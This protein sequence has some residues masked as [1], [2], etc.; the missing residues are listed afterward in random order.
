[1]DRLSL[2]WERRFLALAQHIAQWSKDPSTQVGAVIVDAD[3]RVVGMGYNG[4]PRGVYD[5]QFRYEDRE[6]KYPRVIHAEMNAILNA[7]HSVKDCALFSWPLNTCARCA[8]MIIQAGICTVYAQ[9]T[10]LKTNNPRWI[11]E[12]HIAQEMYK[13]AGITIHY[14]YGDDV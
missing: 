10:E 7:T 4:F 5:T 9:A 3:K 13:E 8:G 11:P 12:W 14:V 6:E 1:M 2:K